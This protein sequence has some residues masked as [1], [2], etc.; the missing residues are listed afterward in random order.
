MYRRLFDTP[1]RIVL[2]ALQTALLVACGD[3]PPNRYHEATPE[4]THAYDYTLDPSGSLIRIS[5]GSTVNEHVNCDGNCQGAFQDPAA[6]C[7]PTC[8]ELNDMGGD[9]DSCSFD[10]SHSSLHCVVHYAAQDDRCDCDMFDC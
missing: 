1:V 10:D 7:R 9:I 5:E 8:E 2:L 4:K 6:A 3:C